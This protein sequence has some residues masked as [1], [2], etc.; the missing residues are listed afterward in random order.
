[1]PA[2]QVPEVAT[3]ALPPA[4][5]CTGWPLMVSLAAT[6]ATGV[7][8]WPAVAL[9]LSPPAASVAAV[10]VKLTVLSA[11]WPKRSHRVYGRL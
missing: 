6:L 3:V 2:G 1:M 7:L 10:S 11:Q 8:S 4:P 9:Q 5:S